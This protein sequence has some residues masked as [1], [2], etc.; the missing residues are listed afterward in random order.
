MINYNKIMGCDMS[1]KKEPYRRQSVLG[2]TSF[3]RKSKSRKTSAVIY[4]QALKDSL[5]YNREVL[6]RRKSIIKN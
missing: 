2:D 6:G 3:K 1:I 4:T 5:E